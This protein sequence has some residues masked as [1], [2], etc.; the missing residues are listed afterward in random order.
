MSFRKMHG[1]IF[2]GLH[3]RPKLQ[4]TGV[5]NFPWICPLSCLVFLKTAYSVEAS[6]NDAG[7]ETLIV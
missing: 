6:A 5:E 1:K 2:C 4:T 3:M 7:K